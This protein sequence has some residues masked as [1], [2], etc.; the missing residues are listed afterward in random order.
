MKVSEKMML[1]G[2]VVTVVDI[3]PG[4]MKDV[5]IVKT[6]DGQRVKCLVERL[7]PY[8]EKPEKKE[9][10]IYITREE[11]R[12]AAIE[13]INPDVWN[14]EGKFSGSGIGAAL[15]PLTGL[16]FSTAIEKVL[17]GDSEDDSI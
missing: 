15:I 7:E 14:N 13:A 9:D 3:I 4:I 1:N 6:Q 10:G 16:A 8:V 12:L 5:A 11:F 2:T 17:F